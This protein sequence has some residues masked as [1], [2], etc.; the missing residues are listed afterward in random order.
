[1]IVQMLNTQRV[2]AEQSQRHHHNADDNIIIKKTI[3]DFI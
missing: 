1:M 2:E 3:T